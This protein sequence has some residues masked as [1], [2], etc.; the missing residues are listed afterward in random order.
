MNF[1][2]IIDTH[3][4]AWFLAVILFIIAYILVNKEKDR[5]V[6]GL[7][8]MIRLF[9]LIIIFTGGFMLYFIGWSWPHVLKTLLGLATITFMEISLTRKVKGNPAPAMLALFV[10][11]LAATV[12]YGFYL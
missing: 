9:Y 10:I 6:K 12:F 7:S 4:G 1:K 11:S 8:M 2:M 5:A 3:M